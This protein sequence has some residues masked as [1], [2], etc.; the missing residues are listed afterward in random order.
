MP[1]VMLR[2]PRPL[3]SLASALRQLQ[4]DIVH[5]NNGGYPGS[6]INRLGMF[7][8]G[9]PRIMTVNTW[10]QPRP[11]QLSRVNTVLDHRLW[12][13]LARVI[14][15]ARATGDRL[16]TLRDLPTEKLRVVHY[17]IEPPAPDLHE[18]KLLRD[19]LAP[20]G[21]LLLGMVVAP[22]TGPDILYKGHDVLLAALA[23]AGRRDVRAVIV[24]HDPGEAFRRTAAERGVY[25]Q[26]VIHA[27]FRASA[28]YMAAIDALV[29][30][31]T[32]YE[33]LPLVILEALASGTPVLASA[34]SGVPEAVIDGRD[35]YLFEPGD[36]GRL[37]RLIA[38]LAGDRAR[39][40][41]LGQSGHE[42]YEERF[43]RTRMVH[44]T[45]AVYDEARSG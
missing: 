34:V 20:E 30:P 38:E 17:G 37:S 7:L 41:A 2:L 4:P 11:G 35:G 5:S 28:P 39:L 31:S 24:G 25:E 27:G 45:L 33:A 23:E 9:T 22:S 19:E 10:P 40:P 44:D 15:P 3:L 43:S 8:T 32:R 12:S 21:E 16:V 42:I 18:V 29:M 1:R 14:A 13:A 6:H 36:A 26:I